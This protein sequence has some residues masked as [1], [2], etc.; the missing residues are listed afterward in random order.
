MRA[1]TGLVVRASES[2]VLWSVLTE[3]Q[4]HVVVGALNTE[5]QRTLANMTFKNFVTTGREVRR[6]VTISG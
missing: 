1:L 6:D 3:H 2:L 5:Q 4:F